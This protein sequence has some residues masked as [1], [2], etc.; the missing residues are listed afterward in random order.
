MNW[1]GFGRSV[2]GKSRHYARS[3]LEGLGETTRNLGL[4]GSSGRDSAEHLPNMSP[5]RSRHASPLGKKVKFL[6][7]RMGGLVDDK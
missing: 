2:H 1:E 4:A 5:E 7:R 3:C 6:Q